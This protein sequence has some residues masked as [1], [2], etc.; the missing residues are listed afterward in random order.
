[1]VQR[2]KF[3]GDIEVS[4]HRPLAEPSDSTGRDCSAITAEAL[5]AKILVQTSRTELPIIPPPPPHDIFNTQ[6]HMG[7]P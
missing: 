5:R 1:V 3:D 2:E 4:W 7:I 6:L